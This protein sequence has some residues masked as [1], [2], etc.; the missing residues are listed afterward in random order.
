MKRYETEQG[1]LV[2]S[3]IVQPKGLKMFYRVTPEKMD[4]YLRAA[5]TDV[6]VDP[7]LVKTIVRTNVKNEGW[8]IRFILCQKEIKTSWIE[9]LQMKE[10]QY[11]E[12]KKGA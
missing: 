3:K 6:D 12:K 7:D 11:L 10:I 4:Q 1:K 9:G 5:I 2:Q 8:W